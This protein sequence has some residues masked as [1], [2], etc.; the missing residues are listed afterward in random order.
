[1]GEV[2]KFRR[3]VMDNTDEKIHSSTWDKVKGWVSRN[4]TISGA[5]AGAAVGTVVPGIGNLI[6]AIVGAGVGFVSSKEK[7]KK[8]GE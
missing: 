6:G 8:S 3:R 7:D 2:I 5:V 1:M 4:R